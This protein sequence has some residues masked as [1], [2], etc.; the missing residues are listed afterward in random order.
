MPNFSFDEN[1]EIDM[2]PLSID[3]IMVRK[4]RQTAFALLGVMICFVLM[5]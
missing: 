4:K 5:V 1:G 3:I 2:T